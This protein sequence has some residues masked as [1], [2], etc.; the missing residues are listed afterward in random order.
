MGLAPLLAAAAAATTA[1]A[2][3][4][5]TTA[6][7]AAVVVLPMAPV[8]V[9]VVPVLVVVSFVVVRTVVVPVV[10]PWCPWSCPWSCPWAG[11][12]RCWPHAGHAVHA[13]PDGALPPPVNGAATSSQSDWEASDHCWTASTQ[14]LR[15]VVKRSG[16]EVL[17]FPTPIGLAEG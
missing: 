13:E 9:I 14:P 16:V 12:E 8:V 3:A 11:R 7:P 17:M 10:G 1:A 4:T 5:A 6:A 2:T 15:N